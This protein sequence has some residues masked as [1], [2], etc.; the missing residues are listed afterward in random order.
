ML[1]L[2]NFLQI[3]PVND[4]DYPLASS[5]SDSWT[6]FVKKEDY[7]YLYNPNCE[8]VNGSIYV[9]GR[10]DY[11]TSQLY[12]SSFNLSGNKE[13]ELVFNG[14]DSYLFDNYNNLLLLNV[15]YDSISIRKINTSGEITFSQ[16]FSIENNRYH[17][18]VDCS[19]F[20]GENN[21]L[22]FVNYF[23]L[24][25]SIVSELFIMK[26]NNAGHSLWN[27]SFY[28]DEGKPIL[29]TNSGNNMYL[30]L[31]N[32]S[33]DILVKLNSSGAIAWQLGVENEILKLGVDSDDNLVIF[34]RPSYKTLSIIKLNSTG[35]QIKETLINLTSWISPSDI[36]ILNDILLVDRSSQSIMCYDLNLDLNWIFT[37][38]DYFSFNTYLW[39]IM[40]QDSLGN[41]YIINQNNVDQN[42]E[43]NI[44]NIAKISIT[45]ELL[46]S[47]IWGNTVNEMPESMAIDSDNNI[48]F[49]C[50]CRYYS[51]WREAYAYTILVKN[52]VNGGTPP[53]IGRDFDIRDHFLFSVMGISCVI[54]PISLLIIIRSKGKNKKRIG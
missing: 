51:V 52:P 8:F 39:Q 15:G 18:L 12:I 10:L 34:R 11:Y 5:N 35:N 47:I 40:A 26:F 48:Y 31:E 9:I 24:Y 49:T 46:S 6:I 4:R 16:E 42:N 23:L 50:N 3:N 29:V 14:C 30:Y 13:W 25:H 28:V 32:N 20:L 21:S 43:L 19:I 41:V 36:L 7:G 33:I 54:S 45:G 27:N 53:E 44:F 22:I 1:P 17:W 38:S 2:G 37:F